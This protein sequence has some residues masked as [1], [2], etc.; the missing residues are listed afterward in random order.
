MPVT[1]WRLR[2]ASGIGYTP[3]GVDQGKRAERLFYGF[4]N[5]RRDIC[6]NISK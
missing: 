5:L 3:A 2:L 4:A 1:S 6:K